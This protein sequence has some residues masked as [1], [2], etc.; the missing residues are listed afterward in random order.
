MDDESSP[1]KL[2]PYLFSSADADQQQDQRQLTVE[3]K[4]YGSL[5]GFPTYAYGLIIISNPCVRKIKTVEFSDR[6]GKAK[7]SLERQYDK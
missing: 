2:K 6:L 5:T 7:Q 4:N 3:D 1:L